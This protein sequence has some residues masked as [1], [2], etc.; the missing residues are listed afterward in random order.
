[1]KLINRELSWLSF[2]ERVLQEA[3]DKNVP[4]VERL[5]FLGIYSNNLDEFFR[6]RVATINRMDQIDR[7]KVDGFNGTPALLLEEIKKEVL[8]QQ[9]KFDLAYKKIQKELL[10]N[11]IKH[12]DNTNLNEVITDELNRYFSHK[13]KHLINPILLSKKSKFPRL[14]ESGVFLAIEMLVNGKKPKYALIEIPSR[15]NRFVVLDQEDKKTKSIILIDDIIR[16]NLNHIFSIFNFDTITAHTFKL[17]RDAELDF[18]DDISASFLEKM[19]KSVDNR[20]IGAPVRFVFDEDMPDDMLNYLIKGLKLE[21][22]ENTIPGGRY[23]NFK[24]FMK[25]PDFG[26]PEFVYKKLPALNHPDLIGK[27]IMKTVLNQDI[28]L[29]YPYQKFDYIVNMLQEAALDPKVKSI[30]I[31]LYRVAKN[32]QI[33]NA[34]ISAAKNGKNVTTII[35][36]Q[37]RFDEENNIFWSNHLKESGVNIIF[38]V[39]G[40]KVHSKLILIAR[41]KDDTIDYI[42][43]I[44]TG[45]FHES[46]AKIYGDI[47]LLTSDIRI[48]KE[49]KRVFELF[50]NNLDRSVYRELMVSPFNT[51]RKFFTLIDNEIKAAKSKKKAKITI[52]LNNLVDAKMIKKLYDASKAGVKVKLIIRGICS[53]VPGVKNL[54]ENIQ[55]ISIVDRF[56]EHVRLFIFHNNNDPLYFISSADWMERNLDKRIEVTTPIYCKKAQETIQKMIDIQLAD[57]Q[58]ARIID[59]RQSNRYVKNLNEPIRSQLEIY[60]YFKDLLKTNKDL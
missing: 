32:S 10:Q 57:N 52:K 14:K 24:D 20:K 50:Y 37:A 39:P 35:E 54:S 46:T 19:E 31:N 27:R 38:G 11:G 28:L 44:G 12:I 3:L 58:K 9:R 1:V 6:V 33:I 22:G 17:T 4:L 25:F 43:H 45:N 59:E 30:H 21:A 2:N 34:L 42:A 60:D 5:R 41:E 36:L 40:M 48:T 18:D 13:L 56:L 23:H 8:S 55:V 53:L 16:L 7:K 49:V 51:R 29:N 26:K 15:T 47:S